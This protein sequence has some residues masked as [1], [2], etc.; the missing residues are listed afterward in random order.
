[1]GSCPVP[2]MV[3]GKTQK[4]NEV[5]HRAPGMHDA[6]PDPKFEYEISDLV[7]IDRRNVGKKRFGLF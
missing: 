7:E 1:M 6:R 3:K 5:L 2:M 4:I